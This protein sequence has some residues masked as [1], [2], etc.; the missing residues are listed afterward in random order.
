MP[1]DRSP[2]SMEVACF[3]KTAVHYMASVGINQLIDIC[4]G[5]P[6]ETNNTHEVAQN[7]RP[8]SRTV[9]VDDDVQLLM[10]WRTRIGNKSSVF[11][12]HISFDKPAS[13]F[14]NADL[15]L[16]LNLSEPLG[17]LLRG[18]SYLA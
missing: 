6:L 2:F 8:E 13:L 9:Y 18:R 14:E 1:H 3:Y 15:A 11:I 17:I 5:I 7:L 4:P 16:R 12:I 10:K